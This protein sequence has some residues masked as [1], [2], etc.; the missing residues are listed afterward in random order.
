[1]VELGLIEHMH[2]ADNDILYISDANGN[3]PVPIMLH[4]GRNHLIDLLRQRYYWK[5]MHNAPSAGLMRMRAGW[6]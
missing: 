2:I 1:M 3:L 5:G 4:V 6:Y